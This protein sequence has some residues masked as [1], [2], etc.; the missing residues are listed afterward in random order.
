MRQGDNAKT[1]KGLEFRTCWQRVYRSGE[2]FSRPLRMGGTSAT[3][4]AVEEMR[5]AH[6]MAGRW[7][8]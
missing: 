6:D 3:V 5:R 2:S 4:R 1:R 8:R 7:M